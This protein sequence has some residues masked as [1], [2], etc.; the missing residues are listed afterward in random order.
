MSDLDDRARDF[1]AAMGMTPSPAEILDI[2]I[3]MAVA[4]GEEKQLGMVLAKAEA[5]HERLLKELGSME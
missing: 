1:K 5:K 2:I 4:T 3:R